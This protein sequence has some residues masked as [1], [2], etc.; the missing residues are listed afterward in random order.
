VDTFGPSVFSQCL[1]ERNA[2]APTDV[3][4]DM[5]IYKYCRFKKQLSV[6]AAKSAKFSSQ[7]KWNK[8]VD[9]NAFELIGL[10]NLKITSVRLISISVSFSVSIMIIPCRSLRLK[11][12]I[13][14]E[15]VI[16]CLVLCYTKCTIREHHFD[17][18]K[19]HVS[20]YPLNHQNLYTDQPQSL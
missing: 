8:D 7:H 17:F 5:M 6:T 15:S 13:S 16:R 9:N 12:R 1:F 3:E 19:I 4:P 14:L 20:L 10:Q 11:N 18:E 2:S